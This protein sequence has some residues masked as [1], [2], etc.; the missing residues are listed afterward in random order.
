MLAA[1][2]LRMGQRLRASRDRRRIRLD[3]EKRRCT[4]ISALRTRGS[5]TMPVLAA[6]G[7]G[8]AVVATTGKS[9]TFARAYDV[10]FTDLEGDLGEGVCYIGRGGLRW[11]EDGIGPGVVLQV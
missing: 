1:L 9:L 5:L 4:M 7:G 8:A 3:L 2:L 11:N 6:A 10:E